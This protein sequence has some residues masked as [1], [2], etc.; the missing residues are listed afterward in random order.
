MTDP[1]PVLR[2]AVPGDGA[3]LRSLIH[4]LAT[5]ERAPEAVEV[6]PE[7]LDAQ[8]AA[9]AP[10]FECILVELPGEGVLGFALTFRTYST[11]KGRAGTWLE[12]YFV[13]PAARGRGLG[14]ALLREVARRAVARGDGRLELTALDWNTPATDIYRR[15][16]FAPQGDWTT[17][18]ISGEALAALAR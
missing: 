14:R 6:T 8:L 3:I 13:L 5:Y 7:T 16:G 2:D 11:W 12:D 15:Q 4:A 9:A 1:L 10:P 18:R 17:W